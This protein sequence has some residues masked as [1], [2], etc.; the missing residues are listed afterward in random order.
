MM[1][2]TI[3]GGTICPGLLL[4][5]LANNGMVSPGAPLSAMTVTFCPSL[6]IGPREGV[7]G[8]AALVAV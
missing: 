8:A 1:V 3:P 6:K 2:N 5:E 7:A 4:D